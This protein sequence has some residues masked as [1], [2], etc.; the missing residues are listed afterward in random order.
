[1][2]VGDKIK[3]IKKTF[4]HEGVIVPTNSL[5]EIVDINPPFIIVAFIDKEGGVHHI[6]LNGE[7]I[8]TLKENG[9]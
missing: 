8:Q 1:M 6:Q 7:E 4:L 9:S 5:A 2:K 3:I